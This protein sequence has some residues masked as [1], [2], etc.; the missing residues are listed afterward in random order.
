[1]GD[2]EFVDI[3]LIKIF[4]LIITNNCYKNKLINNLVLFIKS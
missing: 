2:L 3:L 1:M 4:K